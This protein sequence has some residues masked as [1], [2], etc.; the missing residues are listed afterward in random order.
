MS[1][2]LTQVDD[3]GLLRITGSFDSKVHVEVRQAANQ[4]FDMPCARV[5]FDLRE[6]S[7]IDSSAI[8]LIVELYRRL[9]PQGRRVAILGASDSIR[10][11]IGLTRTDTLVSMY[12]TEAEMAAED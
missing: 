9:T 3:C 12:S 6:C 2:Q 11:I 7:Y 1:V 5:V 8:G 10:Y 4:A